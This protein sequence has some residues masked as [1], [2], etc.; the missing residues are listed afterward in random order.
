MKQSAFLISMC[1]YLLLAACKPSEKE[2]SCPEIYVDLEHIE[3][4]DFKEL[5]SQIE[6]IPLETDSSLI[7]RFW[8][9]KRGIVVP[10]KFYAVIDRDYTVHLFDT[11]G[12]FI[13]NSINCI[14]KGPGQF[15]IMQ[16]VIF[17]P[18]RSTFDVLDPFN[19][20]YSYSTEFKFLQKKTIKAATKDRFCHFFP[21]DSVQ[22]ALFDD[23]EKGAFVVYDVLKEDTIQTVAYPGFIKRISANTVLFRCVN[24]QF[25]LVPPE[26]NRLI[27]Q[28]D[29]D[30]GHLM[31]VLSI[32]GG[33]KEIS[34]AD[35]QDLEEL[36]EVSDFVLNE[37]SKFSPVDR[38]I[39][40][41][42]LISIYIKKHLQYVNIYNRETGKNRTYKREEGL[43]LNLPIFIDLHEDV[44]YAI[45]FPSYLPDYID[46]D[47]LTDKNILDR[48]GEEDNPCVIKY[49][50]KL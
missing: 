25:F 32:N 50:L 46:R 26:M 49:T 37:S 6:I 23:M 19:N 15:Q 31:P 21:F 29:K 18:Y 36:R 3:E 2:V 4:P 35:L 13:A 14:G 27:F 16:D 22:Y 5:F 34:K 28:Y 24:D 10:D 8:G 30:A 43:P 39:S 7:N 41:K 20:I 45:V 11:K 47:L 42:Y 48:I 9:S 12:K 38:L 1:V 17:N 33:N 40:Q 44:A